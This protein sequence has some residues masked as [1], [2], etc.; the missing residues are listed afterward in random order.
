MNL[1][2]QNINFNQYQQ[3]INNHNKNNNIEQIQKQSPNTPFLGYSNNNTKINSNTID[4]TNNNLSVEN[5]S[6]SY[7]NDSYFKKLL[8]LLQSKINIEN[9]VAYY[10]FVEK[11]KS[12]ENN[13]D[14]TINLN[15]FYSALRD[16]NIPLALNDLTDFFK[17]LDKSNSNK[18][19]TE[20]ILKIIRGNLSEKRKIQ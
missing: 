18:V 4:N 20:F 15:S 9:G 1:R 17:Y 12:Y 14:N 2:Q 3:I 19:P 13:D 11:L 8:L 7:E 6:L 16:F 5:Y 10:T